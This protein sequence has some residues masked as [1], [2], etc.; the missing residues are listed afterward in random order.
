MPNWTHNVICVRRAIDGSKANE[1]LEDFYKRTCKIKSSDED[2]PDHVDFDGVLPAPRLET[3]SSDN[4]ELNVEAALEKTRFKLRNA[5][6]LGLNETERVSLEII[7]KVYSKT[8]KLGGRIKDNI[9]E[10]CIAFW[11]TK[12][13]ACYG[14]WNREGG[15]I[16]LTFDTAW[17]HPHGWIDAVLKLYPALS[18][19]FLWNDEGYGSYVDSEGQVVNEE[20]HGEDYY[21]A[22]GVEW[23]PTDYVYGVRWDYDNPFMGESLIHSQ[24]SSN[25]VPDMLDSA[26]KWASFLEVL[27]SGLAEMSQ[28]KE[29]E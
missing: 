11:G 20:T 28:E 24:Q 18:F 10:W 15:E 2:E 3:N 5:P 12:W 25:F 13:N 26:D 22:P 14:K 23:V 4:Y 7:E 17:N 19:H 8:I 21:D 16:K 6:Q 1:Q 29:E 27:H 9:T